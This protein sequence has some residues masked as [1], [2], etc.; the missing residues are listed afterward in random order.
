MGFLKSITLEV[1]TDCS[2]FLATFGEFGLLLIL[3]SGR[4]T[5]DSNCRDKNSTGETADRVQ[6]RGGVQ[7][8]NVYAFN[9]D[10]PNSN[11]A[12]V[13]NFQCVTVA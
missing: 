13:Y 12:E 8:V 1:I 11:P 6:G 9:Y 2:T 3:P 10:D 4:T 5:N 7:E